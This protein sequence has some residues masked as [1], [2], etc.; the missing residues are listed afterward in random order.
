MI[1]VNDAVIY[2]IAYSYSFLFS[3]SQHCPADVLVKALDKS[4][5]NITIMHLLN[6]KMDEYELTTVT[7]Y[8]IL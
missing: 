8:N 6:D 3:L 5:A 4:M 7:V 1:V 2:N